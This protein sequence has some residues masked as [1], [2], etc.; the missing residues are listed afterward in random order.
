MPTANPTL[1]RATRGLLWL[2][3]GL[4]IAA[5]LIVAGVAVALVV[6]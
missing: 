2:T 6:A 4:I 5:A 3:L 1:L